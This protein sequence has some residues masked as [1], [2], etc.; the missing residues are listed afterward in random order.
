MFLQDGNFFPGCAAF[1]ESLLRSHEQ[2]ALDIVCE[3]LARFDGDTSWA[4]DLLATD[5]AVEVLDEVDKR[6]FLQAKAS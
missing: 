6:A 3:R 2:E 4:E 1:G 5:A